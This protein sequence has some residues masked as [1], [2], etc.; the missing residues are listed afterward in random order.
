[1][2]ASAVIQSIFIK[3]GQ[4]RTPRRGVTIVVVLAVI[5]ISLAL[6]YAMLRSQAAT[7]QI[8]ENSR[9][10]V[11]ARSAAL[12]GMTAAI[13]AMH[14]GD[15]QGVDVPLARNIG[16]EGSYAVTFQV[17]DARLKPSDADY[18]DWPYRVTAISTGYASGAGGSGVSTHQIRA[19]LRL[20]P[21]RLNKA[22]N[23]WPLVLPYTV[24]HWSGDDF[25]MQPPARITGPVYIDGRLSLCDD[26]P[27]HDQARDRY[28][29]DLNLIRQ[30]SGRSDYR[31]LNGPIDWRDHQKDDTIWQL[32]GLLQ[33]TAR[34]FKTAN[35]NDF[36]LPLNATEYQL[37]A[38]G[39][40]YEIPKLGPILEDAT[41]EPNLKTNPLGLFYRDGALELRSNVRVTGT[42]VVKDDVLFT[43]QNVRLV[44]APFRGVGEPATATRFPAVLGLDDVLL[45]SDCDVRIEGTV[46]ASDRFEIRDGEESVSVAIAGR[47]IAG[48]V[49][50]D[51]RWPWYYNNSIWKNLYDAFRWQLQFDPSNRINYF[52]DFLAVLG[53]SSKPRITI[54]PAGTEVVDH[55]QSAEGPVYLPGPSDDGLRW[56]VIDWTD[57][58]TTSTP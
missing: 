26:Y 55:W 40:K 7:L 32:T 13:G 9:R 23:V 22:P 56:D 57:Q 33:V 35:A 41:L 52:P 2:P 14:R 50:I 37:Y 49:K 20:Q 27:W 1:M 45:S 3:C 17:G 5:S 53:R 21:K 43:G 19:V 48:T 51:G 31:P 29:S 34:S 25:Q 58:P 4:R 24:Y 46:A 47:V 36:T 54:E 39:P 42:L 10:L 28:L 15:W 12:S 30:Q 11:D 18:A 6:S 44:A 38:G 16:S 8:Q